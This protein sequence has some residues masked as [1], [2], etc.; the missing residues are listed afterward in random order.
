MLS[1]KLKSVREEARTKH[2][3]AGRTWA[4]PAALSGSLLRFDAGTS[5]TRANPDARG[6][7]APD[8]EGRSEPWKLDDGGLS[9]ARSLQVSL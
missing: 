5:A 1:A 6:T 4:H 7:V 3:A 8:G 9:A 2:A